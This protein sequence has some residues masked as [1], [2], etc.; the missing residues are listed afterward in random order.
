MNAKKTPLKIDGITE[1]IYA[2]FSLRLGLLLLDFLIFL[3][4]IF[5]VLYINGLSK[6]A[7]YFNFI[8][9]L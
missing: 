7:Y 2:G 4:Y 6:I 8:P 1:G 3:P 5:L 9:G